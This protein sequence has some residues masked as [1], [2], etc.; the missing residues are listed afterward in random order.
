MSVLIIA[1]HNGTKINQATL[2]AISGAEKLGEVHVLVAGEGVEEIANQAKTISGVTKVLLAQAPHY[3]NLL[4]EEIAPLIVSLNAKYKHFVASA[5]AF[6]KNIIPRVAAMLD[7]S[8]ISDLIEVVNEHT[9][10][11]PMYAG[12]A[13]ETVACADSH[14][15]LTIRSTVFEAAQ[16]GDGNAEIE[17]IS[18]TEAQ[19]LSE[20]IAFEMIQSE[21]PEL[22]QAKAIV[23][24]GR[25]LQSKENFDNILTP[26]A[27]QLNAAIGSSRA[28]VDAGYAPN[29]SQVGQTG[30][31]VAPELYI[32]VGISGAIQHTA[33]IMDS[34]VIVAINKD[35]DAAIFNIADFSLVADLFTAVPELVDALKAAS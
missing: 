34:K 15:A 18:A 30:K 8:Q 10:I 9:F 7:C 13:L 23:T 20:H 17:I 3:K 33:G 16:M 26:L 1:E 32:A 24:G 6:G 27:D 19:N 31:V 21:R 12:N 29:D 5:N 28:A 25:A 35:P 22:A 2:H 11:R 14:L 4:A